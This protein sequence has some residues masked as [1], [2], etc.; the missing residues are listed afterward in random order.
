MSNFN[1]L[2]R[3]CVNMDEEFGA[4]SK[5]FEILIFNPDKV[6]KIDRMILMPFVYC[7]VSSTNI[8]VSSANYSCEI[9]IEEPT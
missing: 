2:A 9:L 4:Y 8:I 3:S 1:Q 5:L 6:S 7:H